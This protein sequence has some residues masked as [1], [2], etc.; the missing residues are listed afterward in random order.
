MATAR[1]GDYLS[2]EGLR[3]D[4]RRAGE[5]RRI[6]CRIG[7]EHA[8]DGSAYVE[9][10]NTKV[11]VSVRGPHEAAKRK[12]LHERAVMTCEFVALPY[13]TGEYKPQAHGD[14]AAVELASA[15][16]HTFEPVVQTQLYPR[17]QIDVSITLLQADGGVR[18][19]AINATSLALIDAGIAMED[20]VCACSAG[21]VQGALLLDLTSQEDNAG[22]ELSVGYL[23][24]SERVGY[25]QLESKLPLTSIDEV[26]NFALQGCR[27]VY[28]VLSEAVR[29]QAQQQL[30]SRG[31]LN[32]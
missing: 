32:A 25:M 7:Q 20:F 18:S 9:Q 15:V 30:A 4:G 5:A 16:R 10:G 2:P 6:R 8:A 24:R 26:L 1:R 22:A 27:Q 3:L 23:P 28:E 31:V 12:Q 19:A 21:S 11:L 17:S 14:R 13:A 29:M